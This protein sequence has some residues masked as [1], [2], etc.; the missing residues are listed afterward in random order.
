MLG[1]GATGRFRDERDPQAVARA[2]GASVVID[3]TV[4]LAGDRARIVVR[5]LDA[6]KREQLWSDRYE[7]GLADILDLQESIAQR[8]AE[9]L[10]LTLTTLAHR[11]AAPPQAI[12]LYLA[13]RARLRQLDHHQLVEAANGFAAAIALAPGFGPAYAGRAMAHARA[14]FME[15]GASPKTEDVAHASVR[16]A[17]ERAPDLAETHLAAGMLANQYGGHRAAVESLTRALAI[18]PTCAAACEY[19]GVIECE[20]G[21]G[22]RGAKRIQLA[23]QLDPG[24]VLGLLMVARQHVFAG[25]WDDYEAVCSTIERGS[26]QFCVPL[27]VMRIR[28]AAWRRDHDTLRRLIPEK[29]AAG[30][31]ELAWYYVQACPG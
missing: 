30:Q 29:N 28:V 12:D 7:V 3:G 23:H 18:A 25:R 19:L 22:E 17:L 13:A 26:P 16:E 10:R 14:W 24:R 21:R 27:L 4:Q 5:L 9:E 11:G 2:L 6:E 15:R 1:A 8:V 31:L 20:A